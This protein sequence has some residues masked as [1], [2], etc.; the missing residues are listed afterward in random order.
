VHHLSASH[1][2]N[3]AHG[4]DPIRTLKT[5]WL[6]HP[7]RFSKGGISVTLPLPVPKDKK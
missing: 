6:P 1:Q 3:P 5:Y 4:I 2:T 7:S